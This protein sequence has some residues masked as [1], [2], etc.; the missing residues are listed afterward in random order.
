MHG[1]S[2]PSAR[3]HALPHSQVIISA[4]EEALHGNVQGKVCY[5]EFPA[6][7]Q[8]VQSDIFGRIRSCGSPAGLSSEHLPERTVKT[9]TLPNMLCAEP[10]I[11]M[12]QTGASDLILPLNGFTVQTVGSLQLLTYRRVDYVFV[13]KYLSCMH[14]SQSSA[15][16][17]PKSRPLGKRL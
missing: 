15:Q 11:C 7:W 14:S 4:A 16:Q 17:M 12:K 6:G 3:Q 2:E 8:K 10:M 5:W 13:R 1:P 9:L